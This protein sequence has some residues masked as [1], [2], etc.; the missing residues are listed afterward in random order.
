MVDKPPVTNLPGTTLSG[1]VS[2]M[3]LDDILPSTNTKAAIAEAGYGNP[4]YEPGWAPI[5]SGTGGGNFSPFS[6]S[7]AHMRRMAEHLYHFSPLARGMVDVPLAFQLGRPLRWQH[8]DE[9]MLE[10]VEAFWT[11]AGNNMDIR[12]LELMRRLALDGELILTRI[13]DPITGMATI[14]TLPPDMVTEI[15]C[16]PMMPDRPAVLHRKGFGLEPDMAWRV[17]GEGWSI[18]AQ[19]LRDAATDGEVHY[20]TINRTR[21]TPRGSG[22]LVPIIDWIR[23]YENALFEEIENWSDLRSFIYSVQVAGADQAELDQWKKAIGRPDPGEMLFHNDRIELKAIAPALNSYDWANASRQF[24]NHILTPRAFPE[25]WFGGGGNV[26][27]ATAAEMDTPVLNIL[28]ERRNTI[29]GIAKEVVMVE[30]L[31]R[32]EATG[33]MAGRRAELMEDLA[34]DMQ[35]LTRPDGSKTA[36][37]FASGATAAAHLHMQG[38]LTTDGALKIISSYAADAGVELDAGEELTAALAR[39]E[40]ERA[41]MADDGMSGIGGSPDDARTDDNRGDGDAAA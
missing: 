4:R 5:G 30:M 39:A 2:Q 20:F 11:S 3:P 15:E 37:A 35:P 24:R 36:A 1:L 16:D 6:T 29:I 8:P 38:L 32:L 10:M 27:R 7:P 28:Q 40:E 33:M 21:S 22:D 34:V 17:A 31:T 26:N 23:A 25:H 9:D 14:G 13:I 41:V 19:A 18:M 12:F